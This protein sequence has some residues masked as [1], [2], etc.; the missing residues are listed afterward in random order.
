MMDHEVYLSLDNEIP[1]QETLKSHKILLNSRALLFFSLFH[2]IS[3]NDMH[4]KHREINIR[5]TCYTR[6][7]FSVVNTPPNIHFKR[8]E[9]KE[10]SSKSLLQKETNSQD[11]LEKQGSS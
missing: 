6:G 4:H 2:V 9:A 10:S 5:T 11:P 7:D 3:P 8:R 1:V